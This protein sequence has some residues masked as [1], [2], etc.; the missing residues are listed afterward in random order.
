MRAPCGG[1]EIAF[2]ANTG[3]LWT[4]LPNQ[5]GVPVGASTGLGMKAGTSPAI[6]G[7]PGGTEIAFQANTGALWFVPP[8]GVGAPTSQSV[9]DGTSPSISLVA[10]I[11]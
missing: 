5:S 6:A 9:K 8:S 10:F 1:Y 11:F 3:I 7:V 2:Q 4:V